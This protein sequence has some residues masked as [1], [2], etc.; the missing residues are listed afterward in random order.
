MLFSSHKHAQDVMQLLQ[1]QGDLPTQLHRFVTSLLT[2]LDADETIQ[3]LRVTISVGGTSDIGRRSY[4]FGTHEVWL[5][6]GDL[7]R[8]EVEKGTL[9]E[10]GQIGRAHVRT[11]VTNGQLVGHILP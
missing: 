8:S 6:I 5:A 10:A 9:R 4:E 11:S 1:I 2:L 3:V 7:L